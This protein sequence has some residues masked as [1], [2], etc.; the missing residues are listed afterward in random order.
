ML[1]HQDSAVPVHGL[2]RPDHC[3]VCFSE[4]SPHACSLTLAQ[5][6]TVAYAVTEYGTVA[7]AYPCAFSRALRDA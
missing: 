6:C 5:P 1:G 7:A 4:R 3:A 2:V